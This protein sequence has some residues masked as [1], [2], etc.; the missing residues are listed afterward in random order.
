MM[1]EITLVLATV[2]VPPPTPN[3]RIVPG[4]S[5]SCKVSDNNKNISNLSL[6]LVE[7]NNRK[8]M[9]EIEPQSHETKLPSGKYVGR[10]NISGINVLVR[11]FHGDGFFSYNFESIYRVGLNHASVTIGYQTVEWGEN[12]EEADTYSEI[13]NIANGIC[14]VIAKN[15][16]G[17]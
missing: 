8:L 3:F 7:N 2:S 9:I 6:R 10:Y 12:D 14:S 16:V 15:E 17:Q 5:V 11:Q 4:S 1:F 13:E